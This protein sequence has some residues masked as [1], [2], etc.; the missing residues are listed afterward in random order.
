MKFGHTQGSSCLFHGT[1]I[2]GLQQDLLLPP[3]VQHLTTVK[4]EIKS[5]SQW[6]I[7]LI[8]SSSLSS[9]LIQTHTCIPHIQTCTHAY[10]KSL[11][12]SGPGLHYCKTSLKLEV[13]NAHPNIRRLCHP[14]FLPD[15]FRQIL[16]CPVHQLQKM[17]LPLMHQSDK[18]IKGPSCLPE[19]GDLTFVP[20]PRLEA[21]ARTG[22]A[23][24]PAS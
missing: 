22:Y 16:T 20:A 7:K 14:P 6:C 17:L 11:I 24:F 9:S 4:R 12:F 23:I 5:L 10:A 18:V 1:Y 19:A 15:S 13:L 8:P 3:S 21:S 2:S